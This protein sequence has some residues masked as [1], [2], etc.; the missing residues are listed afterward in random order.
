MRV[1]YLHPAGGFGGASKSLIELF[2]RLSAFGIVGD[3]VTPVGTASAAFEDAGMTVIRVPGLSQ[4]DNTLYGRYRGLRWIIL[5]RELWFLPGSL[6]R[7]WRL[8]KEPYNLIHA[9]EITLLPL[10]VIAK[11]ILRAPLVVHV[12]SVQAAPRRGLR[13]RWIMGLLAK[14]A[15]AIVAIDETVA[16]TLDDQLKVDVVHNSISVPDAA[17]HNRPL[18]LSRTL[19]LGI[20]GVL[21]PAKGVRELVEAVAIAT[22][23]GVAVECL[24]AG[25][26]ARSLSGLKG[27]LLELFGFARDVRADLEALVVRHGLERQVKFLGLVKDIRSLYGQIDVLCF[28]S[29]LNAAGRPVFEAALF[30]IPSIVAIQDPLPDAILHEETGLAIPESRPDLIAAAIHRLANDEALRERLGHQAK[31]WATGIFSLDQSAHALRTVY[32]NVLGRARSSR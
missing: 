2:G 12:R 26:N 6:L 29:H 9:N 25:E 13:S 15:D 1:L 22:E 23:Q 19:R 17:G 3:V 24:I 7:L 10:A 27:W 4:F 16:R 28:P 14:Y 30:G 8:R 31:V 11:A 5:L 20:F 32:T 18:R 21:I